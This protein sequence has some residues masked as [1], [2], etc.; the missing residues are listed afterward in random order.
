MLSITSDQLAEAVEDAIRAAKARVV[1]IGKL[2]YD[3]GDTQ[4]FESMT[5]RELLQW[6]SEEAEDLIVYGVMARIRI[7]R[8]ERQ[9]K[10]GFDL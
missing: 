9:L 1:G 10:K 3:E 5:I 8:V 2:Q 4:R 7:K 6:A